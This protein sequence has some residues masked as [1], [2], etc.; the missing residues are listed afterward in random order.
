MKT[1]I[2]LKTK[3]KETT[4]EIRIDI[5][6]PQ[7]FKFCFNL[8]NKTISMI[9]MEKY[10]FGIIWHNIPDKIVPVV[11]GTQGICFEIQQI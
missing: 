2:N 5:Q 7:T 10:D 4:C 9:W 3:K 11:I 6:K 8:I 1:C